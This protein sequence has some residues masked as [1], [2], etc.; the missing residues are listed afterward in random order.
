MVPPEA[1]ERHTIGLAFALIIAQ[2]KKRGKHARQIGCV[3]AASG[4]PKIPHSQSLPLEGKAAS[5]GCSRKRRP[6]CFALFALARAIF[7]I[8]NV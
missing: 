4:K 2:P 5:H 8:Y 1:G 3:E 7:S 6:D